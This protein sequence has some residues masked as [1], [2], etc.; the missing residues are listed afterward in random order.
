MNT[1]LAQRLRDGTRTL[2]REAE[3][4][5]IMPALLAG[6]L[7]A[8]IFHALQ[9]NLHPI[10]LALESGLSRHADHAG[11]AAIAR[12][13]L[14]RGPRLAA[15]LQSLHGEGWRDEVPV[16]ASTRTYVERLQQLEAA[17][18]LG[19]VAH[20]YVRYLGDM[21]GG[22]TLRRA[23][24]KA[25]GLKGQD[26]TRFFDFGPPEQAD[27]LAREFRNSLASVP[28]DDTGIERLVAEA[29]WSFAQHVRL[30]R[31]LAIVPAI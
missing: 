31:E 4:A 3:G 11:I 22:Q 8:A 10:Y 20:A 12:P 17:E 15:D 30:F 14:A 19:L 18:P 24:A 5:G 28:V 27:A 29:Q 23:V 7:P 6:R 16:L 26:G 25:F 13:A 21:A 9:R 2:H 1:G